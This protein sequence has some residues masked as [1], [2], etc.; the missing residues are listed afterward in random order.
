MRFVTERDRSKH[1]WSY[2]Q[3]QQEEGVVDKMQKLSTSQM[4]KIMKSLKRSIGG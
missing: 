3:Q 2:Y 4:R 1:E